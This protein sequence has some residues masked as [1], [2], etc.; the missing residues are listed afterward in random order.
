MSECDPETSTIRRPKPE[1]GCYFTGENVY[2]KRIFNK[3]IYQKLGT[4]SPLK[5]LR[6]NK[7]G[8]AVPLQAWSG[9]EGSRRGK[10]WW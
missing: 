8:K 6:V 10:R 5:V 7:E 2:I 1:S 3:M 9:P 4:N